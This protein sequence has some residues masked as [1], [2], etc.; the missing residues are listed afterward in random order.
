MSHDDESQKWTAWQ[1]AEDRAASMW[2]NP[3]VSAQAKQA[4][5]WEAKCA[6]DQWEDAAEAKITSC[7]A[8]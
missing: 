1:A 6:K 8:A 2:A 7:K 3:A 5:C 4:A